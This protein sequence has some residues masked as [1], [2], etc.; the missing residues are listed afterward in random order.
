MK[1]VEYLF[2]EF[3]CLFLW[4]NFFLFCSIT[5]VYCRNFLKCWYWCA[6][7]YFLFF[8]RFYMKLFPTAVVSLFIRIQS[9]LSSPST[10]LKEIFLFNLTNFSNLSHGKSSKVPFDKFWPE[11]CSHKTLS[12]IGVLIKFPEIHKKISV[13]ESHFNKL[14]GL[15]TWNLIKKQPHHRRF[16]VISQNIW[17]A[18]FM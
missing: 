3:F 1:F 4:I 10:L 16:P 15:M 8:I 9:L 12:K 6:E 2:L 17:V 11:K 7:K 18:F 5:D 13:L 14:T